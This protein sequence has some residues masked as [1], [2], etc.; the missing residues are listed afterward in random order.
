MEG[1]EREDK[2]RRGGGGG[3]ANRRVLAPAVNSLLI[4]IGA[5]RRAGDGPSLEEDLQS[6]VPCTCTPQR[7][8][9][10]SW[11]CPH[12]LSVHLLP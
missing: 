3:G 10:A 11:S 4:R 7:P 6:H 5:G 8:G 12:G 2:G 1:T 9:S